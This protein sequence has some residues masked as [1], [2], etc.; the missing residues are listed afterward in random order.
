MSR[1]LR[2]VGFD[3]MEAEN[4]QQAVDLNER[5]RPHLI[6]I[7]IRMPVMDG[8]KAVEQI[9]SRGDDG[10]QPVI[11]ALSASAFEEEKAACLAAGCDGFVHKPAQVHDILEN[12]AKHL[13]VRCRYRGTHEK[14]DNVPERRPVADLIADIRSLS[15]STVQELQER[16]NGQRFLRSMTLFVA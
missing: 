12:M 7:D 9:R 15:P 8:N 13:G 16:W 14:I 4:G 10:N 6:W 11:I 2:Q 3:A 5:F 1:L